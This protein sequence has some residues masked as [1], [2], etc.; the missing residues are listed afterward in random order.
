[1]S[2]LAIRSIARQVRDLNVA[3]RGATSLYVDGTN[4]SDTFTGESWRQALATIQEAVDV[5]DPWTQIFIRAGA[6]DENVTIDKDSISLIG[7]SRGSVEIHPASGDA[8]TIS[9]DFVAATKLSLYAQRYCALL[10]GEYL[11]LDAVGLDGA[12]QS[13]GIYLTTPNYTTL[14]NIYAST[15]NLV[16]AITAYGS[17]KYLNI[18]NC[19][20][21]LTYNDSAAY[22]IYSQNIQ[23]SKIFNNDIGA[24]PLSGGG[25]GI[26]VESDCS[27]LSIFHNNFI[28]N[29]I[30]IDDQGGTRISVFENFYDDHTNV[31]NGF[32]IAKAP[33]SYTGGTDPRPVVARNGWGGLSWADADQVADI[34]ADVTG[35]AGAAMRGTDNAAL[36]SVCTDARLT[37]L[38]AANLPADIDSILANQRKRWNWNCLTDEY[39]VIA[40]TWAVETDTAQ[41]LGKLLHNTSDTADDEVAIPFFAF[42]TDAITLNGRFYFDG[43]NGVANIYVEDTLQGTI[44]TFGATTYNVIKTLSITPA[45]AGMNVLRIKVTSSLD[46]NLKFSELWLS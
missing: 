44:N 34:L 16:T 2:N 28:G 22:V 32:G 36:A 21:N 33:Y 38:D 11:T 42:S 45:R 41:Y 4:G 31:D 19:K 17:A 8:L 1:M 13:Q 7:Q 29:D 46:Y 30:Q 18:S 23:K 6:Y 15:A 20:F 14:N 12:Y 10:S 5:A 43:H 25:Y 35:L 39:M 37:E 9:G 26:W 27:D 24:L 40:G 3:K